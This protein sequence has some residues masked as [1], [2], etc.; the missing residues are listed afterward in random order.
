MS[1]L[2]IH[3]IDKVPEDEKASAK[4]RFQRIAFAYAI[5]SDDARRKR[6]DATGSTAE[7]VIDS[8]G[9]DWSDFYREQFR[10]AVSADAINRFAQQYKHSDEERDD[11]LAAYEEGEGSMDAVYEAVMLSNVLEDDE[12]FRSIIDAAIAA[13]DVPSFPAY[14][15]ETKKSK[16]ARVRA[17]RA[18]AGEAEE[19]AKELGVHE[20]L[21]GDGKKKKGT[22]KGAGAEDDLAALIRR[23]QQGRAS[24]LD[25][26]AA[27]YGAT[28]SKAKGKK[29][30]KRGSV[31]EDDGDEPSE[32]AFQAAAARLKKAKDTRGESTAPKSSK[33]A[34][35]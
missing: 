27:K 20:K 3:N 31:D 23:N 5:L 16:Q 30:K 11:V 15:R 6:Y 19:Y 4:E 14:A 17:A 35:H 32:E 1:K 33:K 21:F 24:F 34:R 18:E 22:G 10:D 13:G 8:D 26:L 12:R 2:T 7:S 29:G 25:D 9:F 28:T